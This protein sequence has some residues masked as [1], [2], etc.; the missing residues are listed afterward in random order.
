MQCYVID[1]VS[2]KLTPS[3][4]LF[5]PSRLLSFLSSSSP[6][7][8]PHPVLFCVSIQ[9]PLQRTSSPGCKTRKKKSDRKTRK[10]KGGTA[11]SHQR[12]FSLKTS[13]TQPHSPITRF[14]SPS[15]FWCCF[16]T[17]QGDDTHSNQINYSLLQPAQKCDTSHYSTLFI[18]RLPKALLSLLSP[19]L[20]IESRTQSSYKQLR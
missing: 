15:F 4:P 14:W 20:Q 8:P 6:H 17:S 7:Q 13:S 19:F 3:Y 9:A 12:G 10:P 5:L 18:S 2:T 11:K 1:V 16:R